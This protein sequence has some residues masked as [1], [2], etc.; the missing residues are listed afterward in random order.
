MAGKVGPEPEDSWMEPDSGK[1]VL[2]LGAA[3]ARSGER[4]LLFLYE[5][6]MTA[7]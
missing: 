3:S 2:C 7:P 1:E 6:A 5:A 4:D